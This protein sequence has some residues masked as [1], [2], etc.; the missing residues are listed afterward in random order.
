MHRR[1]AYATDTSDAEWAVLAPHVLRPRRRGRPCVHSRRALV[2][3]IFYV[4][5]SGCQWRLLPRGYPP[6]QT[7]YHYWRAWRLDGTWARLHTALREQL[8]ARDGRDPQPSAGII[9]SQSVK[10]TGVGGV[11]GYDGAKKVGGRKRHLLVDGQGL[12]LRIAVHSASIPDRGGT[13]LLL[14]GADREFPRLRHLWADQGYTSS[15]PRRGKAWIERELGWTVELT[16]VRGGTPG[17]RGGVRGGWV[18]TWPTDRPLAE[19]HRVWVRVPPVPPRPLIKW[20][21]QTLVPRRWVVERTFSWLGQSRRLAKD[22]ERRC[23]TSEIL[24]LATMIRL[25]SR[26]LAR[27]THATTT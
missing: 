3:A 11:R 10:T 24:V 8:R 16:G 13:P 17:T 26:R 1:D 4:V 23:A 15:D 5:R 6:W 21:T 12:V 20:G 7:V 14:A 25:M 27:A 9:D 2:D 19:R 22:Y 18:P